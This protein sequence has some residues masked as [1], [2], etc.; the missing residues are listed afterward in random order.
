MPL[1]Q[2]WATQGRWSFAAASLVRSSFLRRQSPLAMRFLM[3]ILFFASLVAT[4]G[5]VQAQ[6]PIVTPNF[7]VF[8]DDVQYGYRVAQEAE[9][10]RKELSMAWLGYEIDRW[11]EPCPIR[12]TIDM[13]AGGETSFAFL[14]PPGANR[15]EPTGWEMKVF[16]PPDRLL[17]AVLPHEITHTIFATHFGRPLPRWADEG[18]CTTVEHVSERSKNHGMLISFLGATPSR[19]IPFNRM[20]TMKNYPHDILPLY[21]QG[22]SLARFLIQQSGRRQFLD[23]IAEG[24]EN[25]RPGLELAAWDR[26]TQRHYGFRDLS[27]LQIQWIR[28]VREGSQDIPSRTQL[29]SNKVARPVADQLNDQGFS[30]PDGGQGRVAALPKSDVAQLPIN[31]GWYAKQME[32]NQSTRRV[33]SDKLNAGVEVSLPPNPSQTIWR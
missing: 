9:R 33:A 21:A 7:A 15:G 16:G 12:V 11:K 1:C 32:V 31:K 8:A 6:Q 4:S 28:W 10:Y 17:D 18:A 2:F 24:L 26:A 19:G 29:A 30:D 23:Y 22:Y 20:F 5:R 13:H 3:V 27:E 25:E 14:M